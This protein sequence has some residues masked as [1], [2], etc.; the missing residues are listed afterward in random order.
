[1]KGIS[2]FIAGLLIIS[3]F[4]VV[5][6][7]EQDTFELISYSYTSSANTTKIYP[8]SKN[9]QL[10]IE[11]QYKGSNTIYAV[12]GCLNLPNG[13]SIS[14]GSQSCSP[15][16]MPNGTTY[17]FVNPG[18]TIIFKYSIDVEKN[19]TPGIYNFSVTI[20]YRV[21]TTPQSY[22]IT[23]IQV[24]V[25]P[26]PQVVVNVI[27]NYWSPAA[28]PGSQGVSLNIV[29]ENCGESDVTSAHAILKLPK[30]FSPRNIELDINAIN[31]KQRATITVNNIDI[32][33]NLN[34]T[35]NYQAVLEMNVTA[36]TEDGVVYNAGASTTFYI[37]VSKPPTI[38][39]R[40]IDYGVER[41]FISEKSKTGSIYL[42]VQ[43]MDFKDIN[44]MSVTFRL[45][46]GGTFTNGKSIYVT[47]LRG[48]YRY[49]DCI[50]IRSIDTVFTSDYANV[51]VEMRIFGSDNGAEF[52]TTNTYNLYVSTS[53]SL[54]SGRRLLLVH[55][56]W[57][58]NYP[59]YPNT[60]NAT[61]TVTLANMWSYPISGINLRL[62][63]PQGFYSTN[64]DNPGIAKAYVA[65]PVNSLN[66]FSAS[67]TVSVGNVSASIYK[68]K[69][70]ITY[71]VESNNARIT[72]N[73]EYNVYI[74]INNLSNALELVSASWYSASPEPGTY[75][76]YLVVVIRNNY[77]PTMSGVIL[78]LSLPKG[79][80]CS[81]NN[82]TY[83]KI[84]P[85]GITQLPVQTVQTTQAA[86]IANIIRSLQGGTQ[87]TQ[88]IGKGNF[89]IFMIPVNILTDKLGTY[90]ATAYLNFIDQW[91]NKRKISLTLP[92]ILLGS[93]RLIEVQVPRVISFSEGIAKLQLTIYNR[94]SSTIYN[95]YVALIPQSPLAIPLQNIKY[96]GT[97]RA[98]EYRTINFTL[99]YNPVSTTTIGG[100][101]QVQYSSLPLIVYVMYKDAL[102]YQRSINITSAVLIQP[103]VDIRLSPDTRAE[104]KESVLTITG[105]VINYGI[106]QAKSVEVR[107]YAAGQTTSTFIGDIDPASQAAFR[108]DM[109]LKTPVN[110]VM[111]EIRYKDY[112][113]RLNIRR[114]TLTVHRIQ[115]TTQQQQTVQ[116]K[117]I[118][119]VPW[120]L[121]VIIIVVIFMS[122]ILI[123]IYRLYKKH[124]ETL[125]RMR[126]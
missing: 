95:V 111:V 122:I 58:N 15:A 45:I 79:F 82:S 16:Y 9:V 107:A 31:S 28:Y 101:V 61:F 27:D 59:V 21:A 91:G 73:E 114:F 46:S 34:Y 48:P 43:N 41:L 94:G 119:P 108:I 17:N 32:S 35:K 103:F 120:E 20:R 63:L 67:F 13:F 42:I 65:G 76:A 64:P 2:L 109:P 118:L 83:A 18:D 93:T 105:V 26:Y 126:P 75:G 55:A 112:Y 115:V 8:G 71:V 24:E 104:L 3:L 97:L 116:K 11:I 50:T 47:V 40:I 125:E 36:R 88:T 100:S 86:Q 70:D 56:G 69:L 68:A 80:T 57:A 37:K 99:V 85:Y 121:I 12:T 74:R 1:M 78:E 81:I 106:V 14:R 52:W 102:G 124:T 117:A 25:S 51:K 90:Y 6:S 96:I 54:P 19:V 4:G 62:E 44:L 89:I 77:I 5:I 22:I 53:G 84:S 29:L 38:D 123:L 87:V 98:G 33:P 7:L 92:I 60:Q 30:G 10:V 113:G 23:G 110:K 39:L 49:G 72:C 66:T